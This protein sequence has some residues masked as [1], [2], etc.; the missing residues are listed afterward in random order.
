[1]NNSNIDK[2]ISPKQLENCYI[3]W[4][5][6]KLEEERIKKAN[7]LKL[8]IAKKWRKLKIIMYG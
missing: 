6:R 1:M 3:I 5:F 8:P 2:S 7:G 4:D